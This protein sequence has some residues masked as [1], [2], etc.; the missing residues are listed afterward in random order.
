MRHNKTCKFSPTSQDLLYYVQVFF[1]R[2]LNSLFFPMVLGY[3]RLDFTS[4]VP[5][6]G[7]K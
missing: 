6:L 7:V 4:R 5:F 1:F 3:I 2:F